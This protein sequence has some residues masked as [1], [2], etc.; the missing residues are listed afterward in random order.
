MAPGFDL[1]DPDAYTK[2]FNLTPSYHRQPY[3]FISPENPQNS[4]EGKIVIVVGAGDGIGAAAAKVWARA[5]AE[6]IVLVA[7]R[8]NTLQKVREEITELKNKNKV[9]VISADITNGEDVRGV[10]SKVQN[11]FGRAADVVLQ[12]AGYSAENETIAETDPAEWW[13]SFVSEVA[14]LQRRAKLTDYRTSTSRAL[15]R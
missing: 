9:L 6:G 13:K 5:G 10:F 7:R 12:I 1:T 4:Q 14:T 11:E 8:E 15:M 3:P 2:P